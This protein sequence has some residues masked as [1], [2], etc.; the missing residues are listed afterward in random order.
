NDGFDLGASWFWP[1]VQP[2]LGALVHRLGLC[3]IDQHTAGDVLI[4]GV[5]G[6]AL[7]RYPPMLSEP[8][9]VRIVGGTGALIRAVAHSLPADRI[10]FSAR[11]THIVLTPSGAELATADG[12][13]IGAR[14]IVLAVPPRL[15]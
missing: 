7:E 5:A 14:Q 1:E 13:R 4:E 15:L 9:W 3:L 12:D 8:T 11:V 2:E 10:R 6:Q